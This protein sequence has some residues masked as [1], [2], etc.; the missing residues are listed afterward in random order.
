M[1][2]EPFYFKN[3]A[4][5]KSKVSSSTLKELKKEAKFILKNVMGIEGYWAPRKEWIKE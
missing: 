1:K 4:F 3:L 2:I 5:V